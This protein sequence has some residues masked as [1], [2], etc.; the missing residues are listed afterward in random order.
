MLCRLYLKLRQQQGDAVSA[1]TEFQIGRLSLTTGKFAEAAESFAAVQQA[2]EQQDSQR[3]PARMRDQLMK[4]PEA[5]YALFGESYLRAKM[6]DKAEAAFRRADQGKPEPAILAFRLA[7]IEKERGNTAQA[8][9]LLQQYF[10]AKT[11]AAGLAPYAL[12]VE[13]IDGPSL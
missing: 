13:L 7:L 3:I 12:L 10:D 6:L 9:E 1:I 11:Q 8:L 2:L 4:R 5:T